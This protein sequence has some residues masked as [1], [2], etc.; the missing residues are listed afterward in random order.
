MVAAAWFM[1]WYKAT[2]GRGPGP[3]PG[4]VD[5]AAEESVT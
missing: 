1:T 3:G 5:L 4:A 2:E